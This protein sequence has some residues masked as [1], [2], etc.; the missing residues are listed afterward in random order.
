MEIDPE[1]IQLRA[2]EAQARTSAY[3][4]LAQALVEPPSSAFLQGLRTPDSLLALENLGLDPETLGIL[5]EETEVLALMHEAYQ[6][7]FSSSEPP[8]PLQSSFLKKDE[9][10]TVEQFYHQGG[11][12]LRE[13]LKLP[14]DH[15]AVEL[16]FMGYLAEQEGSKW[17]Q[18]AEAAVALRLLQRQFMHDHLLRWGPKFCEEAR[19]H[20]NHPF[21]FYLTELTRAFLE[22]DRKFL[23]L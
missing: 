13:E 12:I 6:Q 14:A 21:Y 4:F 8:L 16:A 9:T 17:P 2:K 1:I 10:A 22:Q 11:F 5:E 20:A 15:L 3:R 19:E 23:K 7:L 18:D